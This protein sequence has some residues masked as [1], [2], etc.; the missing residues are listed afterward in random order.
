MKEII[1]AY[2]C[3]LTAKTVNQ[4]STLCLQKSQVIGQMSIQSNEADSRSKINF[5]GDLWES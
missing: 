5:Y 4:L 1:Q 3:K 2:Q